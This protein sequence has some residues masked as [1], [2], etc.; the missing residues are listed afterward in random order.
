MNPQQ[1]VMQMLMQQVQSQNPQAFQVV[2]QAINSGAN[3]M[4]FMK[5]VM[6][7]VSPQQMQ[8]IMMQAKQFGVPDE[9]LQQI[10]NIK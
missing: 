1:I 10:Q 4:Q 9:I 3:P 8:D 5:Q 7:N 6:G 2:N